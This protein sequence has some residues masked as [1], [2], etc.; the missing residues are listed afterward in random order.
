MYLEKAARAEDSRLHTVVFASEEYR[1]GNIFPSSNS[2]QRGRD[3]PRNSI[4]LTEAWALAWWRIGVRGGTRRW[5]GCRSRT[6]VG[7]E[8][9]GVTRLGG[10]MATELAL[11]L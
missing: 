7:F 3:G 11:H 6:G 2:G 5:A 1:S 8:I 9:W 4:E 10:I